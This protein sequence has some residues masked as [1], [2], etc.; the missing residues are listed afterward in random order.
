MKK[1]FN[2]NDW[3]NKG[4]SQ[5]PPVLPSPESSQCSEPS[6][7]PIRPISSLED[8]IEQLVCAVE[9]SC[10]D[11]APDYTS[12]RDLA[13]ALADALGEGGRQYFHRLSRFYSA[14]DERE[15]DKQFSACLRSHGSGITINTLF[16]LAKEAGV[17]M[18][19]NTVKPY[20]VKKEKKEKSSLEDLSDLSDLSDIPESSQCSES[21]E[22]LPTFSQEIYSLL[23]SLLTSVINKSN[24]FEDA[25]ILI[26]GSLTVI[27][28]CLPK[29]SGNYAER[30][31][32]PNLFTF[33]SAQASA[34][35]GRLTL[36][37]HLV[38]PIHNNLKKI[39]SA[40]MDEYR[41]L[42]ND[43]SQDKKNREP[44]TEPPIKT[45]L[46]PANSSATSVYQVLNDNGGVGLIFETEGD[47]LANT[48]KSDYGNFSDGFRKAFHHE[49]ISYTRRKD[50][51]FVELTKPRLSALLSGTPKQILALIPDAENGLFSR[52]VFYNMNLRLEWRDVF[53]EG[54]VPL[55]D[56][57]IDLGQ[58]YF[59]FYQTLQQSQPIRFSLSINQQIEFNKFFTEIQQEYSSLFGL[60][61]VASV[62]RLGLIT[63]RVAM[64]LTSLRLMDG[65]SI[66]SVIVCDDTD[67]RT[68]LIMARVLLQHTAH[69]FGQLPS[70]DSNATRGTV[71]VLCQTFFDSL[72]SEF[73][74]RT[75]LSIAERLHVAPKTAEKYIRKFCTTGSLKHLA[76]DSYS[77]M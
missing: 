38:K 67:F 51:E 21:S 65:K 35:K 23:P 68:S 46:I 16:H 3:L 33:I 5:E 20:N 56:Y 28:A 43:Y 1:D 30:E 34:G 25:D 48:F 62:R 74:R 42:L 53:S 15:A 64:I 54:S 13:F 41:H 29:I 50:R 59:Q 47:T 39:Y 6:E 69:V 63:F 70:T 32:F 8:E 7:R 66:E 75:Y 18:I 52:F 55:D 11:I 26:L 4:G 45:L 72:P 73:N 31:V 14:Y 44:P 27:S 57:F 49:M 9:S 71:T 10:K 22:P 58:R 19:R 40:E 60:D 76:H 61:I 36:C 12:W 37:R 77:K 17:L 2:P 24:N